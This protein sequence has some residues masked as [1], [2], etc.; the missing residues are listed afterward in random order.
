L[1]RIVSLRLNMC[2]SYSEQPEVGPMQSTH[3]RLSGGMDNSQMS[4]ILPAART[5]HV[6]QSA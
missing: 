5:T 1:T 2:L 3:Q 4:R 6:I